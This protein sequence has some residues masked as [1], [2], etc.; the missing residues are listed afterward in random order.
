MSTLTHCP[1]FWRNSALTGCSL[2]SLSVPLL[3]SSAAADSRLSAPIASRNLSPLYGNSGVPV[4]ASAHALDKG[5]WNLDWTLHWASHSVLEQR[6]GSTL[7]L[8]GETRRHDLRLQRGLGNGIV[9]SLSVPYITNSAG[10]LD[11]AIDAW[12][13]FWGMPDGPRGVQEKDNLRF[14]YDGP[15]GFNLDASRSGI[16][17]AELALN[18]EALAADTWAIGLFAQYKFDTGEPTDFTGSGDTGASVGAR[19]S[20]QSCFFEVLTCHAQLGVSE[21]GKSRFDPDAETVIPFGG[22]S[23][24]WQ[25]FDSLAL[26]AQLDAHDVIYKAEALKSNG[27]PVWGTLGLRWR[28]A[29]RWLA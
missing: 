25:L 2:L 16:G 22:L 8:D 20:W 27:P 10:E 9:V 11:G 1:G 13:A 5:E 12:H 26:L 3:A 6:D 14:A 17:D 4:M 24:G 19:W 28:P 18:V 21:V 15:S 23:I 7:E 29:E